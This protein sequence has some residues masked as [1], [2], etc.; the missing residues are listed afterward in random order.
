MIPCRTRY[1]S[2]S[3]THLAEPG[4]VELKSLSVATLAIAAST[5]GNDSLVSLDAREDVRD[6][7]QEERHV[8]GDKLGHVH[9][10]QRS[11][12]Q[13]KGSDFSGLARFEAPIV[14]STERM[15]RRP[16]S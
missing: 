15:F 14:R 16:K 4:R 2:Y 6:E 12:R 3:C 9:V 1:V 13:E 8:L 5:S 10:A 7:R 11:H